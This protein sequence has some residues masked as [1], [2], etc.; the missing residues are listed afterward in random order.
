MDFLE[1]RR[2]HYLAE[3]RA[4]EA[5]AAQEDDLGTKEGWLKVAQAYRA[6]ARET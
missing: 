1:R 5:R 2:A 6:L 4:A 3:A